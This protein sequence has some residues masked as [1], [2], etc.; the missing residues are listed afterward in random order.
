MEYTERGRV[1]IVCADR[2]KK[3][4]W[5]GNTSRGIEQQLT[6]EIPDLDSTLTGVSHWSMTRDRVIHFEGT[7]REFMAEKDLTVP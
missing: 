3:E 5:A 2:E 4:T 7:N 6:E 1:R